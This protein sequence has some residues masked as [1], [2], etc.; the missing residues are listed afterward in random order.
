MYHTL[1]TWRAESQD[2]ASSVPWVDNFH[3]MCSRD[4]QLFHKSLRE[5]FDSPRVYDVTGSRR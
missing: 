2:P 5:Y 1:P 3:L 4:N